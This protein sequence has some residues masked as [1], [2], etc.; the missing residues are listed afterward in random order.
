[1]TTSAYESL[2]RRFKRLSALGEAAGIL[3]W[4][5]STMMPPGGAE[6]RGGPRPPRRG[7][8][9]GNLNG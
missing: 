8:W 1:M 2:E 6:A 3:R 4:D 9:D 5:M 7:A